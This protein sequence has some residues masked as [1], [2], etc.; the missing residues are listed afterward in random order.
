M[1]HLICEGNYLLL[2][3]KPWSALD[4]DTTVFLDVPIEE[5]RRRLLDRWAAL[6]SEGLRMKLEENDLPNAELV[7]TS[8]RPADFVIRNV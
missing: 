8:S 3:R 5:L 2:D 7:V 1:R 6:D 4:F